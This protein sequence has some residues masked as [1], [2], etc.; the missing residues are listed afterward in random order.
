MRSRGKPYQILISIR[1]SLWF[2]PALI[3]LASIILAIGL[4]ETDRRFGNELRTWWPRLFEIEGDGATGMLSAIASSMATVAGVVF[5]ITVVALALASTQYT[6]RILRNFMRDRTTQIVLGVFIGVYIY[7]LL[8][9]RTVSGGE[10]AFKPAASVLVAVILA[11][12]ATGYFIFFIHHISSSI[13]ASQISDAVTREAAKA[14]ERMFP[15]KIGHGQ[16]PVASYPPADAFMWT[17][18]PA[19]ALGYVQALDSEGM[20]SYAQENELVIR[21]ECAIGD[22]I[23]PGMPL[24]SLHFL[25][26]GSGEE[27]KDR[28]AELNAMYAIGSYRTI[29]QDAAFGIRQLVDIALKA[30]SPGINDTTTA[31]TCIEHLSYLLSL[32]AQRNIPGRYRFADR[33]L[34]VIAAGPQ[35]RDLVALAFNQIVESAPDN[36]EVALQLLRALKRIGEATQLDAHFS[37][38][39]EQAEAQVDT[40]KLHAKSTGA[41]KAMELQMQELMQCLSARQQ[42]ETPAYQVHYPHKVDENR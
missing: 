11:V 30:L 27:C 7:C 28:A 32:C 6:S 41:L 20:I 17:P 37:V 13:Q 36:T 40:F 24:V 18:V 8:V 25:S 2:V 16:P 12:I 22:F 4:L 42:L 39:K 26:P 38:L 29:E 34:C 14:I 15:E 21:M 3:T 23:A 19:A 31:V 33:R 35:F 1:S 10:W 5:S 9:L